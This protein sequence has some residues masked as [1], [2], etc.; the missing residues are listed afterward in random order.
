VF[1]SSRGQL[2]IYAGTD[3]DSAVTWSLVGVFELAAPIGRRCFERY[4]N[5]LLV[6]TVEGVYAL[7]SILS[8]D[9]ASQ[10]RLAITQRITNAMTN[11]ARSY[12]ANRGW[13][14]CVYPKGT[15]LIMNVPTSEFETAHQYVMN[16][17][18]GAWCRYTGQDA[19]CWVNYNDTLYFGGAGGA[20][21]EADTG[22][23]DVATP[24]TAVGETAYD[25]YRDPGRTKR[26]T[27][28]QP[29][30][31]STDRIF[32]QLG[33]STDFSGNATLSTTSIETIDSSGVWDSSSW[34]EAVYSQDA[35]QIND[36][37]SPPAF[38]KYGAVRF[39]AQTGTSEETA[40]AAIWGESAWGDAWSDNSFGQDEVVQIN[41]FVVTYETGD[42][43]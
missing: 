39:R 24:I 38:G 28:M 41:G 20:V 8:V 7:S 4:G 23:A 3:P 31:I 9:T 17:L 18:T 14:L 26:W 12:S 32:P 22:A 11:A 35:T 25:A 37:T 21:Y 5:D 33:I 34:D 30:L 29:L 43:Y 15:A 40:D 16:T 36:W 42:Y 6:I 19:I 2:A 1:I 13:Q 10:Q 27:A